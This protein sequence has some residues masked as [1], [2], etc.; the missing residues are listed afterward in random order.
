MNRKDIRIARLRLLCEEEGGYTNV[1]R[2]AGVSADNLQQILTGV[3]LPSGQPR[4]IGHRLAEKLERA[5][6]KPT[7]WMDW[8]LDQDAEAITR[9][10]RPLV[11]EDALRSLG[12]AERRRALNFIEDIIA[13]STAPHVQE[14][15]AR[16]FR[17]ID[18]LRQEPADG[19]DDEG[20]QPAQP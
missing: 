11:L 2:I 12:E 15:R 18:R 19:G 17:L 7:G 10:A 20:G 1:A 5:F 6:G 9:E 4:G 3:K 16:Y 14:M 13:S 8:P